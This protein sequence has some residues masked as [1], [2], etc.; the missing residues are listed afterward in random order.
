MQTRQTT[1]LSVPP[2]VLSWANIGGKYEKDGPLAPYFVNCPIL[3]GQYKKEP[4][5]GKIEF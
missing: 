4:L 5:V 2:S 3:C 1:H